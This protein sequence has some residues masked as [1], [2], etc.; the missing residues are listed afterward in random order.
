MNALTVT[1][2]SQFL[3]QLDD[4]FTR[5][6]ERNDAEKISEFAHQYLMHLPP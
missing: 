3:E 1:N 5:K 6:I 4:A 2:K